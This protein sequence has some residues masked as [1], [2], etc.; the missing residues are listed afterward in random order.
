[1]TKKE[2]SFGAFMSGLSSSP[3][4]KLHRTCSPTSKSK[5]GRVVVVGCAELA[6]GFGSGS[7]LGLRFP[8]QR[9]FIS[10]RSYFSAVQVQN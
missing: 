6:F 9:I 10:W 5:N 2:T 4:H 7:A 8:V 3:V 1:M